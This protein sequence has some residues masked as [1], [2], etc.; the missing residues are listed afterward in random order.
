[1]RITFHGAAQAVTGSQFLLEVGGRKLLIDCG[2]FQ[3]SAEEMAERHWNFAFRPVEVDAAIL[4]HAHID[5]S[6]NFPNLFKQ[7]FAGPVYA[8]RA[9]AHLA[10][11]MLRDSAEI[12]E[13]DAAYQNKRRVKGTPRVQP[14]YAMRDAETVSRHFRPV[15]YDRPFQ[16]IPGV[17]ARLVDA[18]HI[19]GSASV[20][21]DVSE[22]GGKTTR[23]WFSGD[24]G[25][26]K[27]ALLRDP[28]LPA[29]VDYLVMESTYGDRPHTDPEEAYSDFIDL[30][31]RTAQRG[32][33]VI[34]PAF[35]VGRTQEL[36]YSLNV[37]MSSGKLDPL[38][39]FV[40]SP[41]ATEASQVFSRHNEVFDQET[42]AF[43]RAERLPALNFPQLTYVSSVAES[44]QIN[45]MHEPMVILSS[46]GMAEVGRI[47]HHLKHNIADERNTIAIVSYQAPGTL[48][49][50]LAEGAQMV[51][52]FDQ[53][54]PVRA[55]VVTLPG[56][57]AHAGRDLLLEY[58]GAVKETLCR[59]MLVHGEPEAARALQ[60]ALVDMGISEVDYPRPHEVVDI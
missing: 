8:T 21:L 18:G 55:E 7:G 22:P 49:R 36:V 12:Q 50:K 34:V 30:V 10:D 15:D 25:R 29:A 46:S 52:I 58:A 9:T 59:V 53:T 13:A 14:L 6:G 45:D 51:S 37:A 26:R 23:V 39:V 47:L 19:L 44:K 2:L 3:G 17:S 33:K 16:P 54:Y 41:L 28:V 48:G 27:L 1:M 20:A 42:L 57:S 35:A 31:R 11:I 4:T 40:D 38:P 43:M 24:I 60:E 5:H 32:G 56:L